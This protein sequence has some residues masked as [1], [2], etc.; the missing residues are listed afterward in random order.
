MVADW[1]TRSCFSSKV[2]LAT[3]D[4]STFHVRR[5]LLE[6]KIGDPHVRIN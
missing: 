4:A 1:L 5:P 3:I 6:D 2:N